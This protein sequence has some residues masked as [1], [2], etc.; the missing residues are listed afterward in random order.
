VLDAPLCAPGTPVRVLWGQP[1]A[2]QKQIRA[3]VAPA[4]YKKDNRRL[5]VSQLAPAPAIP[6]PVNQ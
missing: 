1:G 2:A 5:D 4:P 3:T 6:A